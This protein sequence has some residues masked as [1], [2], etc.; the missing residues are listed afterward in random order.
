MR[1]LLQTGTTLPYCP[2]HQIE[3]FIPHT[4]VVYTLNIRVYEQ[5]LHT[6]KEIFLH[7]ADQ[8][9]FFSRAQKLCTATDT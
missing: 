5:K 9:G 6:A 7:L 4:H 3:E 8:I 2:L 1:C